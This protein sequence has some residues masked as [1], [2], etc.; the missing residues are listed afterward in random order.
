MLMKMVERANKNRYYN[1]HK[2][3]WINDKNQKSD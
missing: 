1:L 2:P 3:G